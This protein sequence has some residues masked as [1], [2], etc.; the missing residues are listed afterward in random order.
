MKMKRLSDRRLREILS[1]EVDMEGEYNLAK[2]VLNGVD[3]S[4]GGVAAIRAM[5][6]A[7]EEATGESDGSGHI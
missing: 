7:V 5:K 1:R 3:N 6:L 2:M 4:H